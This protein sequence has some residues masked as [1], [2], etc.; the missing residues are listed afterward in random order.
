M[1]WKKFEIEACKFLKNKIQEKDIHIDY[2]GGSD[3]TAK[4]IKIFKKKKLN[5]IIEIKEQNA[6]MGQLVIIFNKNRSKF[7]LSNKSVDYKDK[8]K[9]SSKIIKYINENFK[10]YQNPSQKG[11]RLKCDKDL[12]Y[13]YIDN[14]NKIKKYNYFL[15]HNENDEIK[16]VHRNNFKKYFEVTPIIRRKKSGTD[17][18]KNKNYKEVK[19]Y[20]QTKLSLKIQKNNKGYFIIIPNEYKKNYQK[21]KDRYFNIKG[22]KFYLSPVKNIFYIKKCSK[23][24]N[25]NIIFEIKF[26]SKEKEDDLN[27]LINKIRNS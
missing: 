5:T 18:L 21:K 25:P 3:S 4:D 13:N 1:P 16:L 23:T 11:I 14:F 2:L 8:L 9:I 12:S 24:N 27:N 17:Y 10:E 19:D 26:S 20:I 7:N 22:N 15:S 6:Q